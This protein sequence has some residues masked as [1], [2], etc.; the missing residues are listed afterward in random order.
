MGCGV[1]RCR[2]GCKIDMGRQVGLTGGSERV[3]GLVRLHRLKRIA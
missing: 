2:K 3:D 1:G